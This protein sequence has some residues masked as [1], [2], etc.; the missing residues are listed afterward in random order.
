M[1]VRPVRSHYVQSSPP[2]AQ[3]KNKSWFQAVIA[4][5]RLALDWSL[6]GLILGRAADLTSG[7][8]WEQDG[9]DVPVLENSVFSKLFII[10][11][12]CFPKWNSQAKGPDTTNPW[13]GAYLH[14]GWWWWA[15]TWPAGCWCWRTT[16]CPSSNTER[17]WW[18]EGGIQKQVVDGPSLPPR[19]DATTGV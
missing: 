19:P 1:S 14:W 4:L 16:A 8:D 10:S 13:L 12:L 18:S 3:A 15:G 9:Q 2:S 5:Y 6:N 7:N 17:T 11:H